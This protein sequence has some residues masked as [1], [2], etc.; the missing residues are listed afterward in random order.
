MELININNENPFDPTPKLKS[1]PVP[2]LFIPFNNNKDKCNYCGNIY[3]WALHSYQ[4]YCKIC[5]FRYIKDIT[6]RNDVN[7]YLDVH[8]VTKN[9]LCM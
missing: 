7:T 9:T 4:K 8:I 6:D 2:I 1:S 5:L 3:S